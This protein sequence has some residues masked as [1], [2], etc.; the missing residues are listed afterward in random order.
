MTWWTQNSAACFRYIGLLGPL[1][2]RWA[3][4]TPWQLTVAGSLQF[5]KH[6]IRMCSWSSDLRV[7]SFSSGQK[8]ISVSQCYPKKFVKLLERKRLF[9]CQHI[10][11]SSYIVAEGLVKYFQ[12]YEF[13][14]IF[15]FTSR[16]ESV[17]LIVNPK[18]MLDEACRSFT[19]PF[20][21]NIPEERVSFHFSNP[22]LPFRV[23]WSTSVWL[24]NAHPFEVHTHQ[25]DQ[26]NGKPCED[27]KHF[28][29]KVSTWEWS[30]T[31]TCVVEE[32]PF[33]GAL[34][35]NR[36]GQEATVCSRF[37]VPWWGGSTS[38]YFYLIIFTPWNIKTTISH[39]KM[40]HFPVCLHRSLANPCCA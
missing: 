5:S 9:L 6:W 1:H 18:K 21:N 4:T 17:N 27:I 35:L 25:P 15:F 28:A 40:E 16:F 38:K 14:D 36:T 7:R 31:I 2:W 8:D 24:D 32:Y 3:T 33:S 39:H 10:I 30:T 13:D 12:R 22:A 26:A 20:T 11:G 34:S 19:K 37:P 23:R 29:Q